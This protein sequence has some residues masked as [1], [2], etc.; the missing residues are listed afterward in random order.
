MSSPHDILE[1]PADQPIESDSTPFP[2]TA[3]ETTPYPGESRSILKVD[4]HLKIPQI[5]KQVSRPN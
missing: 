1:L 2:L 5:W 3:G 4:W